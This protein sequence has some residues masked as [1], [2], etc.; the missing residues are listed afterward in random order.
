MVRHIEASDHPNSTIAE[1]DT[2][3]WFPITNSRAPWHLQAISAGAKLDNIPDFGPA[4]QIKYNNTVG[5]GQGVNIYI[6][7]SG[8]E[9]EHKLFGGRARNSNKCYTS[10]DGECFKDTYGHGTSVAGCAA[11]KL[12]GTAQGANII[13]VKT[14]Y[15]FTKRTPQTDPSDILEALKDILDEHLANVENPPPGFR[16]SVINMSLGQDSRGAKSIRN[17]IE[18][19]YIA[20]VPVVTAA[21]N[22]R[23]K[24]I[25]AD[26]V[27]PCNMNTICVGGINQKYEQDWYSNTG[28]NV[29]V[30]APGSGIMTLDTNGRTIVT[31][32]TSFAAPLVAGVLATFIGWENLGYEGVDNPNLV[33]SRL[34]SNM[35]RGVLV[36][37]YNGADLSGSQNNMVTSGINNPDKSTSDP[38]KGVGEEIDNTYQE[39]SQTRAILM[40][41]S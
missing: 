26:N 15:S 25:I 14:F 28:G 22:G 4:T 13:N 2:Q 31:T 9:I 16:G 34:D 11:G 18:K 7:D 35:L 40:L 6:I 23:G 10:A 30:L 20:G 17:A 19:L 37:L 29:T 3:P 21:G 27:W 39:V 12:F 33:R 1:R 38:Y 36:D 24:G 8:V 41:W 32:G 5:G